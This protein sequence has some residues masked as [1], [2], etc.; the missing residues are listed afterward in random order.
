MEHKG[1]VTLESERL[2]LRRI[3]ED[4]AQAMY[5][6]W[7]SDPEVTRYLT[8]ETH[9]SVEVSLAVISSWVK[10][11]E[12]PSF[13]QWAIELR[14]TGELVG[15]IGVVGWPLDEHCPEIGYCIGRAWWHQGITSEALATVIDFLFGEVGVERIR[16]VHDVENPNSGG[17]MRHC[18]MSLVGTERRAHRNNR[19]LVDVNV[20]DIIPED[21]RAARRARELMAG[22]AVRH[23]KGTK[24]R[25]ASVTVT[26]HL[27]RH[28]DINGYN[29]LFGGR[30]MEWIDDAAG[31][32]AIRHC[33][34]YVTTACVD[35][36]EFRAPAFLGDIV[37]IEA[38]VTFVG[39]SS[40]EVRV[41]S[42]VEDPANG[43]RA[44]INRAYLTEVCVDEEGKPCVV[45][46]GLALTR[47][48]EFE[49]WEAALFRK[50]FHTTRRASGV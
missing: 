25:K 44:L 10:S 36:L 43:T 42:Y 39:K 30:L 18:G 22:N 37:V 17:V 13:Y 14:A 49:D 38:E 34:M 5:S 19:G 41:N 9:A 28:E 12:D 21:W 24:T 3:R 26:T 1:T 23:P 8:W 46:Y 6:N 47:A 4:D 31:T 32:A 48:E 15:T 33:G 50:E 29:R 16:S 27:L 45:P 11:Y 40:L 35:T 20:Y 7:A 2:T